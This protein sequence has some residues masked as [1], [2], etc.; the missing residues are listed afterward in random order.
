MVRPD[1]DPTINEMPDSGSTK[2]P[3]SG[4]A[5]LVFAGWSELDLTMIFYSY[6]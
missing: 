4:S 5:T 6:K 2:P 1:V 3:E